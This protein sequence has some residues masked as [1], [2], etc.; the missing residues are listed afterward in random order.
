MPHC[1]VQR[2]LG[3][4]KDRNAWRS[5]SGRLPGHYG[6]SKKR[7]AFFNF[8]IIGRQDGVKNFIIDVPGY[9]ANKF[10]F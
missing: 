9:E 3:K 2:H 10:Q 6:Q 1:I 4:L 5:E 7:S 8:E